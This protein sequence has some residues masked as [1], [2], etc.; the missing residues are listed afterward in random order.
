MAFQL[1]CSIMRK[2]L[3]FLLL[4]FG[5][6]A[7]SLKSEN[8]E[9]KPALK[10]LLALFDVP[11]DL[12]DGELTLYLQQHWLQP[13]KE[14][15]EM[16]K[17]HE[18]KRD[19]VFPLLKE[20]QCINTVRAQ[21]S[22]YDYALV[23]GATGK[24]MQRRLDFLYEEWQR[25]VRFDKII[26]LTGAR[27]LDPKI[28]NFPEGLKTET[29]LFLHLYTLHPIY[30]LVPY[31]VIDAPKRI[32]DDGT[33]GRPITVSTVLEWLKTDPE[34]GSCLA[35]STQ[36]FVGSQ[37]AVLRCLLPCSFKVEA[38]GPGTEQNY[39]S[40]DL[41]LESPKIPYPVSI[42]LENF[43]KWLKFEQEQSCEKYSPKYLSHPAR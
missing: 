33:L 26:L 19:Q 37:E 39:P 35:V 31:E 41:D 36:P 38:I 15:W 11:K 10:E 40:A 3:F 30:G 2:I 22:R 43:A 8:G 4:S 13:N 12:S 20:L 24:A 28:E 14:R 42:Y 5:L 18:D 29:D 27:D 7:L 34:P 32:L 16:D 23:L 9:L 6:H 25:G 21:E 1:L 17:R